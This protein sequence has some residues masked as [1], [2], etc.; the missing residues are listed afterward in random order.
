MSEL[1]SSALL[2]FRQRAPLAGLFI[3]AVLGVLASD[4]QP[5]W[6]PTWSAAFLAIALVVLRIRA[7]LS[8]CLLMFIA[9][10]FWHGNQ[11]ATD[12]GYQ[13]SR[14]KP[15]DATEH[16]VTLLV[17]SDP[18]PDQLRSVQRFMALVSCIDN[19]PARFQTSAECSGESF[20]YGD[21]LLAQGKFYLPTHPMNPGE[22]DFGDYLRRQSIYLS[23]RAHHEVPAMIIAKNKGDPLVAV[24]LVGRQRVLESLQVGLQDDT[25]VAQ[26]MQGMVLGARAETSPGLKKLF[27]D[28]GTIHLFAASGLQVGLFTGLAWSGL[29]YVRLPRRSLALAVVPVAIAYCALTGFHPA[30]IR[31]TVM[32]IFIAVGASLERPVATVN[33]LCGSGLL[34]LG[35]D[36]QELFQTGFQLS[37]VAVFAILTA[38]RP[39]AHLLYR[40]FQVDPFLPMRLLAPWQRTWHQAM[41]HTCEILSLSAV[42]WGA[43]API[44]IYQEHRLSLIAIFANLLVVPV[45]TAVMFLAVAGLLA[46]TI[47]SSIT[48]YLNNTS[49]LL[50]KLILWIL[51]AAT[52]IPCHSVNLSPSNLLQPDH[53]TALAEGSDHVIHL[54]VKGHDW[55]INT[56]KLS[57]WRSLTEPYLQFRGVN[58]LDELVLCEA[59]PHVE[60]ILEVVNSEFQVARIVRS[61]RAQ[62]TSSIS[63]CQGGQ[64]QLSNDATAGDD[65]VKILF[66]DQSAPSEASRGEPAVAAVLIHLEKFRILILPTVTEASLSALKCGHADVVYCGRLGN[67]RFPRDLLIN[68]LSPSI[69]VL[70]GTKPEVIANARD[71]PSTTKCFYV[72]QDGAITTELVNRELVIRSYRGSEFRLRSLSR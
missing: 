32:A 56:G 17:S 37:F 6:W 45:A 1:A 36:T 53:V 4:Q 27:R 10:A 39:F 30:T 43:T 2:P 62:A 35:H 28:T 55:L 8:A 44:L 51:H 9:F 54:H 48:G 64:G 42:C 34:I 15:F 58:R 70:N 72:K 52:L 57:Q 26:T 47:S 12:P 60:S 61:S 46:G 13:R 22:F 3:A 16:T 29:R 31:A 14:Q 38:A 11:V 5:E 50:T 7:T 23:F 18:K 67:R 49:W 66:A 40:P 68:K 65:P 63:L 19:H 41:L 33:S 69:L 71:G 20:S 24:A 21:Q 59:Y 25:E